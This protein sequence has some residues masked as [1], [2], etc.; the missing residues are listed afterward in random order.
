MGEMGQLMAIIVGAGLG[1]LFA[2][3]MLVFFDGEIFAFI[4]RLRAWV[5]R[6]CRL[7]G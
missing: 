3:I 4:E 7:E 6:M 5:R 2:L 1:P